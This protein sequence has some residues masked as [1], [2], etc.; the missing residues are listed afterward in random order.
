M[1]FV[2]STID[3]DTTT[4]FISGAD[5]VRCLYKCV[6]SSLLN[7]KPNIMF[8]AFNSNPFLNYLVVR[9]T[10]AN[11][12]LNAWNSGGV[13]RWSSGGFNG[14]FKGF[15]PFDNMLDGN[16]TSIAGE[17]GGTSKGII[18]VGAYATSYYWTDYKGN[19][20]S[21]YALPGYLANFSSQGPTVDGRIK[22]D[23]SAPGV[24]VSS[25]VNKYYLD[26]NSITY[27]TYAGG[28]TNYFGA[29]S[30]TSMAS[31][32]V[33]G[34][35]AL[36][37]QQNPLLTNE[38][39]RTILQNTAVADSATGTTPNNFYGYGK[40]NAL[41][42]LQYIAGTT[43]VQSVKGDNGSVSIYPN[44]V[45]QLLFIDIKNLDNEIIRCSITT[46]QGQLVQK[47]IVGWG[48]TAQQFV[49]DVRNLAQ[50][51][52]LLQIETTTGTITRKIVKQ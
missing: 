2:S 14:D 35:V 22:P 24:S 5:T 32:Q 30:G 8:N 16:D 4:E 43:A 51:I 37:L 10:S 21:T 13:D 49:F 3:K 7:G 15:K 50:G 31:P 11:T 39:I 20:Q 12:A 41:A 48:N 44:P 6:A 42:A 27:I 9:I 52:Y 28:D 33:T 40:V 1:P 25:S 18:S 46:L 26:S 47:Q 29:S 34:I 17:N 19:G 45:S 36:M 23:V 38:Q